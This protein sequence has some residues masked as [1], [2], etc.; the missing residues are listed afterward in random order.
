M[1]WTKAKTAIV[2]G[3]GLLLAAGTATVTVKEIQEHRPYLW[4][5]GNGINSAVLDRVSPQVRIV[6][7]FKPNPARGSGWATSGDKVFG[8]DQPISQIIEIVY[9]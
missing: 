2:V 6:P 8:L 4:E 7:A 1:A 9:G 5:L 3:A